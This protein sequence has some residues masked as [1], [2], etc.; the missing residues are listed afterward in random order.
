VLVAWCELRVDFRTFR[1]D[2]I[3]EATPIEG[4]FGRRR[5]VLLAEWRR[6]EGIP[7]D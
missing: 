3:R 5:A 4:R 2:R 1:I 6:W 7:V